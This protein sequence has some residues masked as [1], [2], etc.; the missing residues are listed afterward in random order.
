[1]ND[2][3]Q[4]SESDSNA[5]TD[6]DVVCEQKQSESYVGPRAMWDWRQ[7][8]ETSWSMV[9]RLILGADMTG[10]DK[11]SGIS[12]HGWPPE[13]TPQKRQS[14]VDPRMTE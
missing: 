12:H 5:D 13:I 8:Q 10:R 14:V 1:M 9:G 4:I 2:N 11:E 3:Y 7:L 6:T